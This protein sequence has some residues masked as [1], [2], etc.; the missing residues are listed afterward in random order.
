MDIYQLE[1]FSAVYR[2]KSFSRASEELHITQPTVSMH[3]KRLEDDLGVKLFDR[4]G[5]KTIPTKEADRLHSKAE[6]LIIKLRSLREDFGKDEENIEGLLTIGTGSSP[7]SYMLPNIAAEFRKLYPKVFFQLVV[8]N[9]GEIHRQIEKGEL[10]IGMV[11]DRKKSEGIAYL[12]SITDEMVLVTAPGYL[13]KKTITPLGI[14]RIPLLMR[15]EESDARRSMEKQHMFHSI[16]LK[17]LN[18]VAILGST[19][20]LKEAVKAGLGA[21]IISRFAVKDDL[22]SGLL[23]EIRIRG[24]KMKR[25]MYVATSTRCTLPHLHQTF[26]AYLKENLI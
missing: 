3:I 11:E 25:T 7:G 5:K 20:S 17:A 4:N 8:K 2:L 19:D 9:T 13:R 12:H 18:I 16:S 6:E 23:E 1:V 10:L 22:K 15:E 14:F 26:I 24:V 21:A